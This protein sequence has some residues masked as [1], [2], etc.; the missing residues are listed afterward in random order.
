MSRSVKYPVEGGSRTLGMKTIKLGELTRCGT[1][2]LAGTTIGGGDYALGR[3][4]R[5]YAKLGLLGC[6]FCQCS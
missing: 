6:C 5:E 1:F 2:G 3:R 4:I